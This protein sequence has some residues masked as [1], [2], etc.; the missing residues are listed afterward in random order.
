VGMRWCCGGKGRSC[1]GAATR[2]GAGDI[3]VGHDAAADHDRGSSGPHGGPGWGW[4]GVGAG[5]PRVFCDEGMAR[6]GDDAMC[7]CVVAPITC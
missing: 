1:F 5:M 2:P 4:H 3:G 6:G 7:V